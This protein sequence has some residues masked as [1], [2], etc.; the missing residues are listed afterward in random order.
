MAV[1]DPVEQ[2]QHLN[3]WIFNTINR[4]CDQLEAMQNEDGTIPDDK[5]AEYNRLKGELDA[6]RM[7]GMTTA[8]MIDQ[9][10]YIQELQDSGPD[11]GADAG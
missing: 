8:L 7:V 2:M 1:T 10:E 3:N 5:A 4:I 11:D 6:Y 9:A